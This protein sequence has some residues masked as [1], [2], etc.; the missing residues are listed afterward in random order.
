M[1]VDGLSPGGAGT[2]TAGARARA[3]THGRKDWSR[4]RVSEIQRARLLVATGELV[5]ARG[6]TAVTVAHIVARAGVSRRT[7][8]DLFD[9]RADC[10][11]ATLD[12]ALARVSRSARQAYDRELEWRDRTRAGLA[13]VLW[14]FDAEPEL[15]ALCVVHALGAGPRALERRAQVLDDL[16]AVV[17]EGRETVRG[18]QPPP[19]TAEGVVG[20]VFAVVHARMLDP[21]TTALIELLGSLMGII[22]LPYQGRAAAARELTRPAPAAPS[23]PGAH[24]ADPLDGLGMRL[25]YRTL[26]VL[27]VIF[28]HPGASN[29]EIGKR[30]G[31]S[32]QGQTSKLLARLQKLQ[33]IQNSG[34]GPSRGAPNV[35]T[36]T[37]KSRQAMDALAGQEASTAALID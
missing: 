16:I 2:S 20:A 32:D 17:D 25:T 24:G 22:V 11:L 27:N 31:I 14:F 13:A 34:G 30:A 7:F 19:L 3:G 37:S 18:A 9:D 35:W 1:S 36:L 15:G 10:L 5:S 26:R 23:L 6:V 12:G 4:Q 8:Y 29:R 33:L 21:A 28:E